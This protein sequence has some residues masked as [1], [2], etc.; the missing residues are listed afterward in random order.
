MNMKCWFPWVLHKFT[1]LQGKFLLFCTFGPE[2]CT[3]IS[4]K[5]SKI[6]LS[7]IYMYMYVYMCKPT[8]NSNS[9]NSWFPI[10]FSFFFLLNFLF[11]SDF[12]SFVS[13]SS[14]CLFFLFLFSKLYFF[15]PVSELWIYLWQLLANFAKIF[16]VQLY[17][18]NF[19]LTMHVMIWSVFQNLYDFHTLNN[20]HK[21]LNHQ[22]SV[23][24]VHDGVK[25]NG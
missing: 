3:W 11:H 13:C 23:S 8:N 24:I 20:L 19:C 21:V 6:L 18:F 9:W 7:F 15:L 12:L 2:A 14:F 4:F 5:N 25:A 22:N 16:C 10:M 17:I 1:W